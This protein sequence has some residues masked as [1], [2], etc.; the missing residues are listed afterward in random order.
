M[1]LFEALFVFDS[2]VI[3]PPNTVT[4]WLSVEIRKTNH[5]M[6]ATAAEPTLQNVWRF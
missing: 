2:S 6:T 4:K 1:C 3:P 5:K